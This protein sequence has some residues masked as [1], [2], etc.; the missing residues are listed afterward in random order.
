MQ[1]NGAVVGAGVVVVVVAVVVDVVVAV[2]V[3]VV[4]VVAAKVLVT[5]NVP[6]GAVPVVV[7]NGT[8]PSSIVFGAPSYSSYDLSELV[9]PS[10]DVSFRGFV[11][12]FLLS[13]SPSSSVL[14]TV[15]L[16]KKSA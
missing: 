10:T 14:L 7:N 12:S 4:V 8:P 15:S 1:E 9:S 6:C 2:G 3:V 11:C 16:S 13:S 5:S